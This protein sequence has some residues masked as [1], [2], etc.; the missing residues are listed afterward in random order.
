MRSSARTV[1]SIPGLAALAALTVSVAAP[2][3]AQDAP[4]PAE[5]GEA[6]APAPDPKRV[7]LATECVLD[8]EAAKPNTLQYFLWERLNHFRLR[9]DSA[10]PIGAKNLDAYVAKIAKWWEKEE[11]QAGPP[12]LTITAKQEVKYDAAEFYGEAQAHNF[13]GTIRADVKDAAGETLLV[14]EFP[15]AWGRLIS[16]G[17]TK[18]QVFMRY[19]Q[20]VQTGLALQ[21]LNHAAVRERIPAKKRKDLAKW[22]TQERDK[23]LEFLGSSTEAMKKS[24][25]AQKLKGLDLGGE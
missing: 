8:G 10:K 11:P 4:G 3:V 18:N 15:F 19:S 1:R 13:K 23:L 20:L 22:S 2:A 6:E 14:V 24:E 17:L 25:L 9:V 5:T 12:S 16:S 7:S 21:V